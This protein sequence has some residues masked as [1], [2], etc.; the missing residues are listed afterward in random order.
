VKPTVIESSDESDHNNKKEK[1]TTQAG[2]S[3]D[4]DIEE[5]KNPKPVESPEEELGELSTAY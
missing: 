3:Q 5:I 4:S 2:T 1:L